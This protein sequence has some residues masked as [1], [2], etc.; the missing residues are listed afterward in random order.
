MSAPKP[1]G[2]I[3]FG[4]VT[5]FGLG[6]P[7]T[8]GLS[9]CQ[10]PVDRAAKERIFSPEDPPKV[11]AASS[12][13][14]P[15]EAVATDPA[16]ASRVLGM[17]EAEITERLGPHRYTATVSFEWMGATSLKLTE[18]R[19]LLAGPGGVNGDFH[20]ILENSRDQGLEVLRV[21]G[22]VFAKSRYGK[23]RQRLRD[24]GLAERTREEVA[25]AVKD[26]DALFQG[27]LKVASEGTVT[28]EGRTAWKYGV[29]LAGEPRLKPD[30]LPPPVFAKSGADETT[31]RRLRFFAER[32]PRTLQGEILVD[33]E[34]SAVLKAT[35]DGTV[36]APAEDG[37]TVEL[38]LTLDAALTE[39]GKPQKVEAPTV[40]LPDADKPQ[41]IA[42]ALDRFGIPRA[43][44]PDAGTAAPAGAE[45]PDE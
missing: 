5:A 22:K 27:R 14:L 35:L 2:R 6:V 38:R 9:G 18:T 23:F 34:K 26:F 41:G 33:A 29:S 25:G 1:A 36:L 44:A 43:A 45:L 32:K 4:I 8:L 7:A 37:G 11:L 20:A 42:D 40:F 15:P 19:T 3:A 31:K 17:G 13:K 24:R 30:I 28:Y 12:E 21:G 10:D 16:V 39:I